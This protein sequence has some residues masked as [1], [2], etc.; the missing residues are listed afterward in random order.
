M[1]QS[2]ALKRFDTIFKGY[3]ADYSQTA[4]S[5]VVVI[6]S[7]I[8]RKPGMKRSELI[9]TNTGIVKEVTQEITK[10][11]PNSVIVVVSN[12]AGRTLLLRLEE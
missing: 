6:I 2:A 7:G 12:P 4:N 3:T 9:A 8:T 1:R 10:Y 11:S 5:E